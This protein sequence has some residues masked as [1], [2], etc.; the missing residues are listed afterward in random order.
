M[1][2]TKT[3]A[4]QL[5]LHDHEEM[6]KMYHEYVLTGEEAHA[7]KLD[8]AEK[9]NK[10]ITLHFSKE[11]KVLFPAFAEKGGKEAEE[12]VQHA[13]EEHRHIEFAMSRLKKTKVENKNFETRMKVLMENLKHHHEDEE[14]EVFPKVNEVLSD[15]L[16]SLG[17]E[18]KAIK[19]PRK[20]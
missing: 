1:E 2:K 16:D 9:L 12:M 8:I 4:I 13:L 7:K 18:I 15:E 17:Q 14:L 3:N 6:G 10:E 11:E 5:L 20:K 19:E